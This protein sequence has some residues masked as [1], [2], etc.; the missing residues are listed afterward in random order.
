MEPQSTASAGKA[1]LAKILVGVVSS[2]AAAGIIFLLFDRSSDFNKRKEATLSAWNAYLNS[3]GTLEEIMKRWQVA[4]MEK[5]KKVRQEDDIKPL[6]AE[7][8][9]ALDRDFGLTIQALEDIKSGEGFD[10]RVSTYIDVKIRQAHD[11]KALMQA[12]IAEWEKLMS[13]GLADEQL[14]ERLKPMNAAAQEEGKKIK[15]RD[16]FRLERLHQ[17]LCKEYGVELP[18]RLSD[19]SK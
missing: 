14:L 8:F 18:V 9:S 16:K 19:P 15:E 11:L 5:A 12:Y 13:M 1:M 6:M 4:G 17:E 10:R 2:V 7:A 3:M